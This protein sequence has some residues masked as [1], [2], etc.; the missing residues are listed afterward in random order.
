MS[1]LYFRTPILPQLTLNRG[2]DAPCQRLCLVLVYGPSGGY[3]AIVQP[4]E[5]I[6]CLPG[7][8]RS[9]ADV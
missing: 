2:D 7:S 8:P 6:D 3:G 4:Q 9:L 1:I 5:G